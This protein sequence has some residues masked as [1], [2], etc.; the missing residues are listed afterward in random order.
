MVLWLTFLTTVF[1]VCWRGE[2]LSS[3]TYYTNS[4]L[5]NHFVMSKSPLK[6]CTCW[7]TLWHFSLHC[8]LPWSQ[9]TRKI[10]HLWSKTR[11]KMEDRDKAVRFEWHLKKKERKKEQSIDRK[12]IRIWLLNILC[13]FCLIRAHQG[14][15]PPCEYCICLSLKVKNRWNIKFGRWAYE[16]T[17][18]CKP[19]PTDF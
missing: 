2:K 9:D 5:I 1:Q 7:E 17:V 16:Y 3:G 4:P 19:H 15:N 11:A 18:Y 12:W 10:R 13:I 14:L 8:P 6:Y